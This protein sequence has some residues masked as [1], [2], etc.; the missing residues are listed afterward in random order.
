MNAGWALFEIENRVFLIEIC[1]DLSRC[2]EKSTLK[3]PSID[4]EYILEVYLNFTEKK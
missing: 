1:F 4:P 2:I 3:Y